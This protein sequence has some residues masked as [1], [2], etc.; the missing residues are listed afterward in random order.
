MY[1]LPKLYEAYYEFQSVEK[2]V[3]IENDSIPDVIEYTREHLKILR[4]LNVFLIHALEV[5]YRKTIITMNTQF[6]RKI[7]LGQYLGLGRE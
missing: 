2:R 6:F 5:D 1:V 4:S 7:S 3:V